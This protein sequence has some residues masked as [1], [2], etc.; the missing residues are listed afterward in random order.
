M[1]IS[2]LTTFKLYLE[3]IFSQYALSVFIVKAEKLTFV[4][5]N[6]RCYSEEGGT[7]RYHRLLKC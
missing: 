5:G 1:D 3:F 7:Y 6:I 2:T 4:W